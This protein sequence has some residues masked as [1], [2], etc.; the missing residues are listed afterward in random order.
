[1]ENEHELNSTREQMWPN[2]DPIQEAGGIN[3][4]G[5]LENNPI[6][7]GDPLG[8][9]YGDWYDPRSYFNNGYLAYY[10]TGNANASDEVLN[11]A[12]EAGGEYTSCFLKCMGLDLGLEGATEA[13]GTRYGARMYYT[14]TD[15]RFKA[16]GRYS[17][18]LLPRLAARANLAMAAWSTVEAAHC[19]H[20]CKHQDDC[21]KKRSS[22]S[23][24]PFSGGQLS[25]SSSPYSGGT[26]NAP[27]AI[28]ITS[29]S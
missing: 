24:P 5:F 21:Q 8:L 27:P 29:P 10:Y 14:A 9:A 17:K 19:M 20:K 28:T 18:V 1:M 3:L 2:C 12:L 7:Y 16:F 11:A 4:Y 15:G 13:G 23:S 26:Q 6:N 25:P 22:P